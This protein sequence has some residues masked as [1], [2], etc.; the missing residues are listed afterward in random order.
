M[1]D[2]KAQFRFAQAVKHGHA[3]KQGMSRAVADEIIN[4]ARQRGVASLPEKVRPRTK[5]KPQAS[6]GASPVKPEPGGFVPGR[7]KP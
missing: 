6:R 5:G 4:D 2:S 7:R 3:R 1:A